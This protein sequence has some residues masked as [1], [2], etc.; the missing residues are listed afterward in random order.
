MPES[1]IVLWRSL[2]GAI[3]ILAMYLHADLSKSALHLIPFATSIVLVF[4]LPDAEPAQPRAV[5]GGHMISTLA[6]LAL[7]FLFGHSP[8]VAAAAVGLAMVGMHYTRTMHPP[9][10]IDALIVVNDHL[11]W[12]FFF[13]PVLAGSLSLVLFAALWLNFFLLRPKVWPQRWL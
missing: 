12:S 5:I 7:A 10:G 13:V 8:W 6:G 2:G 4:G 3:A 1:G 11:T 9:A